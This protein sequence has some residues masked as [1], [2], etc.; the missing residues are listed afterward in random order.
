[1]SRLSDERRGFADP[2]SPPTRRVS[3]VERLKESLDLHDN[4]IGGAPLFTSLYGILIRVEVSFLNIDPNLCLFRR[5]GLPRRLLMGG[6]RTQW[7]HASSCKSVLN[8][9]SS[10]SYANRQ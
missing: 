3:G 7:A 9:I 10:D 1:M 2:S 8:E 4:S 6:T 5:R